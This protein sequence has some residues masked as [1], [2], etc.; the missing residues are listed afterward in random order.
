MICC[1][2]WGGCFCIS[3]IS[4]AMRGSVWGI[5]YIIIIGSWGIICGAV[6]STYAY[7]YTPSPVYSV[8]GGF[9]PGGIV[10]P[11]CYCYYGCCPAAC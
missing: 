4:E 7:A 10:A 6:G 8:A 9:A 11:G 5:Y 1:C 2:T 3:I